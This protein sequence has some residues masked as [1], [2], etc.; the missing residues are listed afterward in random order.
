MIANFQND[1]TYQP[2][3]SPNNSHQSY[4]HKDS[5]IVKSILSFFLVLLIIN[6]PLHRLYSV[7]FNS[8]E[9]N[10]LNTTL[11]IQKSQN[12]LEERNSILSSRPSSE[13]EILL[14]FKNDKF[15]WLT[16]PNFNQKTQNLAELKIVPKYDSISFE[17]KEFEFDEINFF[18]GFN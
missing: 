12:Q 7:Q 13:D 18:S 14:K 9:H 17:S 6:I 1:Q 3:L 10:H 11:Q 2:D 5:V 8:I 15:D 4:L 16:K